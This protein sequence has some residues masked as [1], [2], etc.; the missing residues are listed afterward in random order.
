MK[1]A[2]RLQMATALACG[3]LAALPQ[4]RAAGTVQVDWLQPDRYA[5]AGRSVVDRERT[6]QE[7]SRHLVALGAR[8]PDGQT[9]RLD[10][11]DLDLAGEIEWNARGELRILRGRADW[12]HM[13]LRYTLT[14]GGQTLKSGEA[15]LAD[16]HYFFSPR[17]AALAYEKRMLD[18]WFRDTFA[19]R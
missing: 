6:M 5:D 15:S 8:L 4:A 12:P 11:L 7:L 17:D 18:R 14:S 19:G 9:L 16:M 1:S 2:L 13:T 3:L 10:V